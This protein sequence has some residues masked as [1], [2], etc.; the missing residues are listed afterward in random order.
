MEGGPEKSQS[1]KLVV[2]IFTPILIF[3]V[4]RLSAENKLAERHLVDKII[5][6][7]N[8]EPVIIY[9]THVLADMSMNMVDMNIVRDPHMKHLFTFNQFIAMMPSHQIIRVFM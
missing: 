3:L 5:C 4:P 7:H 8:H 9:P 1:I 6:R 2:K